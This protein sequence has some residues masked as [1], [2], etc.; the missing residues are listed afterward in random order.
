MYSCEVFFF[1]IFKIDKGKMM[2]NSEHECCQND[3]IF[4]IMAGGDRE[5]EREL[6]NGN[7]Q[8]A[9]IV[10]NCDWADLCCEFTGQ[11]LPLFSSLSERRWFLHCV[12]PV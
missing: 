10:K 5:R 8:E 12:F 6:P 2:M 11:Q 4:K 7:V 9:S 1:N 3:N